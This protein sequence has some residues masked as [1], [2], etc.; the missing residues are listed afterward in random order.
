[1]EKA[2]PKGKLERYRLP[3]GAMFHASYDAD[4]QV[5]EAFLAIPRG[6]NGEPPHHYPGSG[7]ALHSL[8]GK[9]GFQWYKANRDAQ[10][11]PPI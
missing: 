6:P 4:K 1:M 2:K 7:R 3:H 11:E 8:L 9:L 5:W 10:K